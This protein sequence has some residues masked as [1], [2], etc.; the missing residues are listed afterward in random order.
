MISYAI[1]NVKSFFLDQSCADIKSTMPCAPCYARTTRSF[2][3]PKYRAIELPDICRQR[4]SRAARDLSESMS[5]HHATFAACAD[6]RRVTIPVYI[7]TSTR[8]AL[9][10]KRTESRSQESEVRRRWGTM[11]AEC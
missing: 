10:G 11:N 8:G 3:G 5:F 7:C 4:P 1:S 9:Q 6:Y 2:V